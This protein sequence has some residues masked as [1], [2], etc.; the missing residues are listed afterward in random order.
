M[1]V[2][3]SQHKKVVLRDKYKVPAEVLQDGEVT[4]RRWR[5]EDA[6]A[7][8]AAV[9]V[10]LRELQI[11]MPWAKNGYTIDDR[12]QFPQYNYGRVG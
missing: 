11:W 9:V 12:K 4:L 5:I 6:D 10:S 3:T 8:L 7:L 2:N 1:S